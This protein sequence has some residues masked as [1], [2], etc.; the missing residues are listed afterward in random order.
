MLGAEEV[1]RSIWSKAI[2]K[3]ATLLD[4]LTSTCL[5]PLPFML[6][7]EGKVTV[8][9]D[10]SSVPTFLASIGSAIA[11]RCQFTGVAI[12]VIFVVAV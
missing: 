10:P 6:A 1:R 11:M 12:A 5:G 3:T 4:G 7:T 8:R 2:A 9:K